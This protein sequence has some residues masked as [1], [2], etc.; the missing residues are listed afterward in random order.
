MA[1]SSPLS[2]PATP[3]VGE[4]DRVGLLAASPNDD[5]ALVQEQSPAVIPAV[6]SSPPSYSFAVTTPAAAPPIAAAGGGAVPP[7]AATAAGSPIQSFGLESPADSNWAATRS[8]SLIGYASTSPMYSSSAGRFPAG[9]RRRRCSC[10]STFLWRA[11][12]VV[13]VVA[14]IAV[15]VGI[16]IPRVMQARPSRPHPLVREATE[17]PGQTST[18]AQEER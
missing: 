13:G 10:T 11:C 15:L 7:A 3:R 4:G 14:V 18:A 12:A 8:E 9:G 1:T 16:S 17:Q 2:P 6:G 5:F